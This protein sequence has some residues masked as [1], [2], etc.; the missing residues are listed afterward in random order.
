MGSFIMPIHFI[1]TIVNISGQNVAFFHYS[2][3]DFRR[4]ILARNSFRIILL[5]LFLRI[6]LNGVP[7]GII[8]LPG[9]DQFMSSAVSYKELKSQN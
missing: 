7:G 6:H 5:S 9:L 4:A 1:L 3:K 8:M 2:H